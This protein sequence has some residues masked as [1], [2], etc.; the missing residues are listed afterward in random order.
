MAKVDKLVAEI[1]QRIRTGQLQPGDRLPPVRAYAD[2]QAI[3]A[4]TAAAVYKTLGTRG[5]VHGEG[6]RGTFVSSKPPV[7]T[8]IDDAIPDDLVDLA[9]GNPDPL[10]LPDLDDAL[11]AVS[12]EHVLYGHDQVLPRLD[13]IL[14]R[15][16]ASDQIDTPDLAVV[17]GALDGIERVLAAHLR[18]GDVVAIEDPAYHA[19]I[20]LVLAMG[21]RP[22]PITV[23]SSGV[24]P[25]E[26]DEALQRG[27]SAVV[28][29]PRAQNPTGA[30]IDASSA[31]QLRAVLSRHPH[32]V[33]IEDD[34]A[35]R[36]SGAPYA[37]AIPNGHPHWAIARSVAKSLGP[38]L[39][40]CALTGDETTIARVRGRQAVGAGWVSF[41][42]Q[43]IAAAILDSPGHDTRID[44][45]AKTYA[46]RRLA[47][48]QRLRDNG[49]ETLSSS[50]LNVWVTVDDEARVVTAMRQHGWAIRPGS[51]FRLQAP[52]GIR[53]TTARLDGETLAHA[54]DDLASLLTERAPIRRG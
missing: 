3:A 24:I 19:V 5:L 42:L 27:A 4:N 28:L 34:H 12:T 33:V 49:I 43:Q 29:T 23:G 53:V 45:A 50:G 37:S 20:D 14:R 16:F 15:D 30:T 10:L 48:S 11:A 46:E 32:V 22:T 21:L 39:R 47:F 7:R 36:I 13:S 52:R 2:Q 9:S 17:G 41:I 6:R 54:A 18:P 1:E 26:L 8:P 31:D 38:D 35:G 40:L 25:A 51:P 44:H